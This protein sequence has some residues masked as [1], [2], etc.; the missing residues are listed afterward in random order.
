MNRNTYPVITKIL[1]YGLMGVIV[2]AGYQLW[3]NPEFIK[4]MQRV[5]HALKQ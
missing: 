2:Y 3:Q 5:M 1:S 4:T